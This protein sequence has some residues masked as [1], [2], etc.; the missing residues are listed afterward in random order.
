MELHI[1]LNLSVDDSL[2]G[3]PQGLN[4]SNPPVFRVYFWEKYQDSPAQICWE[5]SVILHVLR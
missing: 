1:R 5:G 2:G 3:L 4:K